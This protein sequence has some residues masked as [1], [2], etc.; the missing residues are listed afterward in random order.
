M[1]VQSFDELSPIRLPYPI[2]AIEEVTSSPQPSS[3]AK[4]P[5]LRVLHVPNSEL[6]VLIVLQEVFDLSFAICLHH[7]GTS[8][9]G[10]SCSITVRQR[11]P[12]IGD[13]PGVDQGGRIFDMAWLCLYSSCSRLWK[14]GDDNEVFVSRSRSADIR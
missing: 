6:R 12:K 9:Y 3:T 14:V 1:I 2:S 8:I 10:F 4:S 7:Y 5:D 13:D 11:Y